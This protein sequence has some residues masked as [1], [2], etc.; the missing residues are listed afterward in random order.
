MDTG[1]ATASET[2]RFPPKTLLIAIS[3]QRQ[4]QQ[5]EEYFAQKMLEKKTQTDNELSP[6]SNH[7]V[8]KLNWLTGVMQSP[9]GQNLNKSD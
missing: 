8:T 6:R 3:K 7:P 4:Q 9:R 2:L 5:Q 1:V